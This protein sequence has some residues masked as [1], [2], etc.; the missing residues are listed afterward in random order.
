VNEED[1][2]RKVGLRLVPFMMLLYL[3]AF[4][5]RVNVGF[6][7]LTMNKDLGLTPTVFGWGA[8]IFFFGYFIFEVPSN[9]ILERVGA[10]KWIARIMITWGIVSVAMAFMQGP[11]SFFILRFLLGVAEAGFLP[12]MI[13]YLTYWFPSARRARIT[14]LFMAAVPLASAV[15]APISGVIV[16]INEAMGLKGWQW[17]FI[18][19]GL[20][21]VILGLVVLGLLP[22]GPADAT[23]LSTAERKLIQD[24]LAADPAPPRTQHALWAALKDSRVI[25][26][27]LVYLGIVMGLYGVGLW[28]PQIVKA[29]GNYTDRQVGYLLAIPYAA[30]AALM[31]VWG[32]HSDARGERVVHVALAAGLAAI[33]LLS[34]VLFSAPLLALCALGVAS[35]GIYATLGPFWPIPSRFLRGTAAA[36]GIALINAIGNLGGFIGP[37]LVGWVRETTGS[38]KLAMLVLAIAAA[39]AALLVLTLKREEQAAAD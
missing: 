32:R 36:G 4:L 20:P 3:V 8:G 16:S 14:G 15:G 11:V 22:N 12:G 2:Y 26:L 39:I 27:S 38:F 29:M 5:D 7:A 28:L 21:S 33:G 37:Y 23:W 34:S 17:L 18:L 19:E 25:V 24:R 13:L 35:I 6:A 31:L 30:S 10:R 9:V 1:V